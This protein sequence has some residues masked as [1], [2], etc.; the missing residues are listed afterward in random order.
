MLKQCQDTILTYYTQ[1]VFYLNEASQ[2]LINKIRYGKELLSLNDRINLKIYENY[3]FASNE[4]KCQPQ[5]VVTARSIKTNLIY[6]SVN[7]SDFLKDLMGIF[8]HS[9]ELDGQLD[10]CKYIQCKFC[11]KLFKELA[12]FKYHLVQLHT[13]SDKLAKC[14]ACPYCRQLVKC[15]RNVNV[16]QVLNKHILEECVEVRMGTMPVINFFSEN[17]NLEKNSQVEQ[18][19]KGEEKEKGVLLDEF[20]EENMKGEEMDN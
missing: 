8:G 20:L 1:G 17:G 11:L 15:I 5:V 12:E 19:E 4:I 10:E 13:F 16:I 7:R 2:K 14:V 6:T 18:E 9:L 3:F